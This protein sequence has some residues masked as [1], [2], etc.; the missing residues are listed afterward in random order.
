[1]I[2]LLQQHAPE[3]LEWKSAQFSQ[4]TNMSQPLLSLPS[5]LEYLFA[6]LILAPD[7]QVVSAGAKSIKGY[8]Q[9]LSDNKYGYA[10]SAEKA[11]SNLGYA[12]LNEKRVKKAI[13]VFRI[14][15]KDYPGSPHVYTA[16]AQALIADNNLIDALPMQKTA[17][18]LA[19]KQNN[20]Y[21]DYYKQLFTDI[22]SKL[23]TN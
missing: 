6:D 10:I 5:A 7:S 15:L 20:P 11:L 16:L 1:M 22:E 23:S 2:S 13:E 17:Y 21:K 3:N 12:M 8:Y 4:N 19:M 9:Q 18:E 14:N